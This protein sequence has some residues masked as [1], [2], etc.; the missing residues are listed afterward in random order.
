[1]SNKAL[2]TFDFNDKTVRVI[3]RDGK[4]WWVARDVCDVLELVDVTSALRAVVKLII[5]QIIRD[6]PYTFVTPAV[7]V[8]PITV[9]RRQIASWCPS[10]QYPK[11]SVDKITCFAAR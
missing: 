10:S 4:P 9:I 6:S 11:Y 5:I 3:M 7:S 8:F 1:M 2:Q